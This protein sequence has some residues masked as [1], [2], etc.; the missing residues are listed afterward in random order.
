MALNRLE[1][2]AATAAVEEQLAAVE[3]VDSSDTQAVKGASKL[4]V[5][6]ISGATR[7]GKGSLARYLKEQLP[8]ACVVGQ[9]SHFDYNKVRR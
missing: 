6:G 5:V 1:N 7:C 9:D 4:R 8:S 2:T 3:G